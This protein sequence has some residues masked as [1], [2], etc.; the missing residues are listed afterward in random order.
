MKAFMSCAMSYSSMGIIF[1]MGP[2]KHEEKA[3]AK[4]GFKSSREWKVTKGPEHECREE[5]SPTASPRVA[6]R[7]SRACSRAPS[8]DVTT[9]VDGDQ[10]SLTYFCMLQNR[11]LY[12]RAVEPR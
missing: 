11:P 1:L 7:S 8:T 9:Y 6:A 4:S 10:L 2:M 3:S 12:A 5:R